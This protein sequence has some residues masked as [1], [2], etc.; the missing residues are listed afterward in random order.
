MN[1]GT[2]AGTCVQSDELLRPS[3]MLCLPLL[4]ERTC[5]EYQETV[6][7]M[8][9]GMEQILAPEAEREAGR[10]SECVSEMCGTNTTV[11]RGARHVSGHGMGT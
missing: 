1:H 8:S 2:L 10:L 11:E 3:G 4:L 7:P 5:M 6:R 9:R